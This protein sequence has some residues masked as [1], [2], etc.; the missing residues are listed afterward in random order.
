MSKLKIV[1]NNFKRD[2]LFSVSE[3]LAIKAVVQDTIEEP[4][5]EPDEELTDRY[6]DI[7]N[8]LW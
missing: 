5:P 2:L 7:V 3:M 8:S 1:R 6:Y 4:M